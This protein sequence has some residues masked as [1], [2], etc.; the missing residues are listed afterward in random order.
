[1]DGVVQVRG[2]MRMDD[3]GMYGW[4]GGEVMAGMGGW[5]GWRV[6]TG[7]RPKG[8]GDRRQE[9]G[10]RKRTAGKGPFCLD[11]SLRH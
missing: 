5:Y 10:R 3:L 7:S 4:V 8:G 2:W 9:S 1:M 6:W 11:L